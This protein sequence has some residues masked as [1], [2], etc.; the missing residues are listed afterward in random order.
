MIN[1]NPTLVIWNV[2]GANNVAFRR[3]M[4]DLI[5]IHTPCILALLE[6][7]AFIRNEYNFTGMIEAPAF[8]HFGGIVILW[9]EDQVKITSMRQTFQELHAMVEV[10]PNQT[11]WLMFIIYM[12]VPI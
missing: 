1:R 9:H 8:G 11:P 7:H 4:F 5:N 6:N 12:L 10:L 2:R 3:N